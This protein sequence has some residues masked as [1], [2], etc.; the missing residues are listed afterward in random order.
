MSTQRAIGVERR[1]VASISPLTGELLSEHEQ[2]SEEVVEKKISLAASTHTP[3]SGSGPGSPPAVRPARRSWSSRTSSRA[4]CA[5]STSRHTLEPA[6]RPIGP[7]L[8]E[9]AKHMAGFSRSLHESGRY[10]FPGTGFPDET[11]VGAAMRTAA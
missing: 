7:S 1:T 9:K 10:L 11:G 4:G 6:P 3:P 2:H 5:S 8:L